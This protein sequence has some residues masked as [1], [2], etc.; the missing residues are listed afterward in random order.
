MDLSF[1]EKLINWIMEYIMTM[2]FSILVNGTPCDPFKPKRGI[3]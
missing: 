1:A 2:T 3:R